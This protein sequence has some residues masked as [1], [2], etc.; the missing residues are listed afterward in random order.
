MNYYNVILNACGRLNLKT[1]KNLHF[2]IDEWD[3]QGASLTL[4][5]ETLGRYRLIGGW[6]TWKDDSILYLHSARTGTILSTA[7]VVTTYPCSPEGRA[8]LAKRVGGRSV[9]FGTLD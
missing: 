9:L 8:D 6:G 3:G 5:E 7:R 1:G 2:N 4:V